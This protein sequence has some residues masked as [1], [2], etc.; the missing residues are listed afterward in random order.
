MLRA[1]IRKLLNTS[2]ELL[3]QL[4]QVATL[5][6]SPRLDAK[7]ARARTQRDA[8]DE[9]RVNGSGEGHVAEP[10]YL[11]SAPS[12]L[13]R[14]HSSQRPCD[15]DLTVTDACVLA[16]R[17]TSQQSTCAATCNTPLPHATPFR[18]GVAAALTLADAPGGADA[19]QLT[20]QAQTAP[21]YS[22]GG[23]INAVKLSGLETACKVTAADTSRL[24][25]APQTGSK[26]DVA[27]AK[28]SPSTLRSCMEPKHAGRTPSDARPGLSSQTE[29]CSWSDLADRR[30]FVTVR[31]LAQRLLRTCACEIIHDFC[32][33]AEQGGSPGQNLARRLE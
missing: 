15:W 32:T 11:P 14:R 25:K 31:H 28:R 27:S 7:F 18:S 9:T 24:S 17:R 21:A 26:P 2:H 8:S 20:T 16:P 1:E 22:C 13:Q 33:S 3:D 29:A 4:D 6:N 23:A 10:G 19:A 30:K 12:G 5:L